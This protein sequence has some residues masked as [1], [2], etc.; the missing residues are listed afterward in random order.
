MNGHKQAAAALH[1]L[2]TA[3]RETMLAELPGADQDILRGYLAEL[4]ELGFAAAPLRAAAATP[5]DQVRAADAATLYALLGQQP[6]GLVA[7]FLRLDA[8]PAGAALLALFPA[9]QREQIVALREQGGP[10]PPALARALVE[11]LAGSLPA[12]AALPWWR[13]AWQKAKA[14]TA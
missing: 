4:A 13:G 10:V 6:A 3:D 8:W 11:Q 7:Q 14:W 9:P 1:G 2:S 5:A 12:A